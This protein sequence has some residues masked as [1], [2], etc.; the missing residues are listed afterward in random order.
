MDAS[1]KDVLSA[2]KCGIIAED[3]VIGSLIFNVSAGKGKVTKV[4]DGIFHIYFGGIDKL[5]RKVKAEALLDTRKWKNIRISDEIY[6]RIKAG[7]VNL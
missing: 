1:I 5:A 3:D 4:V 7:S 2:I 6:F